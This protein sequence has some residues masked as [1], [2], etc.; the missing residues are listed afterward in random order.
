MAL[1]KAWEDK[2]GQ[3]IPDVGNF[4]FDGHAAGMGSQGRMGCESTRSRVR[5]ACVKGLG[6]NLIRHAK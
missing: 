6:S 5:T 2:I 1:V 4:C 3:S